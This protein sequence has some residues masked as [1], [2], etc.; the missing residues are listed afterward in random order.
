DHGEGSGNPHAA[1]GRP[2]GRARPL[3]S[4]RRLHQSSPGSVLMRAVV[5]HPGRSPWGG[6]VTAPG[7]AVPPAV[8]TGREVALVD[9]R[10]IGLATGRLP[11]RQL[12]ALSVDLDGEEHEADR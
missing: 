1:P 6:G 8:R 4:A 3:R 5:A 10:A 12:I 9:A 11:G 7:L 2:R